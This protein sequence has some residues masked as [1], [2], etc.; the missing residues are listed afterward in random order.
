MNNTHKSIYYQCKQIDTIIRNL[1]LTEIILYWAERPDTPNLTSQKRS[2]LYRQKTTYSWDIP[3]DAQNAI[4]YKKLLFIRSKVQIV[5]DIFG[6]MDLDLRV[7]D[8]RKYC[9]IDV[10][11]LIVKAS[12]TKVSQS[13][14]KMNPEERSLK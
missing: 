11:E 14:C 3:I 12:F 5:I 1:Y 9:N 2:H 4:I 10:K 6:R 7:D 13:H 8:E